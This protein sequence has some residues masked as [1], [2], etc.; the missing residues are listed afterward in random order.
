VYYNVFSLDNY[1]K[2]ESRKMIVADKIITGAAE[3]ATPL[4]KTS[5]AGPD[6]NKLHVIKNGAIA[7]RGDK[8]VFVGT[9]QELQQQVEATEDAIEI[10]AEGCTLMPGF[11]DAHTHTVFAGDR[12]N[13]F[14]MRL[15]GAKYADIAKAGGGILSTVKATREATEDELFALGVER[16][17]SMMIHGTTTVET[18]SGYGLETETELKQLRVANKL[19]EQHPMTIATTFLGAHE[20]PQE[21]RDKENGA[22]QY[23]KLVA[24]EMIPR[25]AKE[26]LATAFDVFV[27][28]GVFEIE[29]SRI[30]LDAAKKHGLDVRIHADQLTP[31]GG[32]ELAAEYGALSA[33][34]LEF[35][36]DK[37]IEAMAKSGT[38]AGLLPGAAF[39]LMM[40]YPPARKII[41]GNVPVMLATDFNPGSSH[42]ES[43]PMN[44]AL[45]CL[46]MKM[47]VAEAIVAATLNAAASLKMADTIGSL[48]VGKQADIIILNAPSHFHLVYHWG[49]NQV[50][51]VIKNGDILVGGEEA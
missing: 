6:Q 43:M 15:Q 32:S 41:D 37:G 3:L 39:F 44:I 19:A 28:T 49:V 22:M 30:V 51:G 45:A 7:L 24:E 12:S 5:L 48:E 27:E 17:D 20:V 16:L 2:Q 46:N 33:D 4:G 36:S 21:Y 25:V 29:T 35:I 14:D 8:I 42:C 11:V 34:H 13:E 38:I 9:E 10:D 26:E 18:K 50:I 1:A 31:L 47:T 23:A 40:E